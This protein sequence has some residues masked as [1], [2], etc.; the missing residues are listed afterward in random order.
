MQ[1]NDSVLVMKLVTR[2]GFTLRVS[3]ET[4]GQ[5]S[6]HIPSIYLHWEN[7]WEMEKNST[8]TSVIAVQGKISRLKMFSNSV[9]STNIVQMI[10]YW[11]YKRNFL[12]QEK[13]PIKQYLRKVLLKKKAD[14]GTYLFV[15][16]CRYRDV[17]V[18]AK[19]CRL[20]IGYW[21]CTKQ[22]KGCEPR[23]WSWTQ[24]VNI[25]RNAGGELPQFFSRKEQEE[26]ISIIKTSTD[27]F[28]IEA[29]FISLKTTSG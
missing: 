16:H 25:C 26:L 24:A 18:Q 22:R 6:Q 2:T 19:G 14:K 23:I 20:W 3:V 7:A 12:H 1:T 10:Y 27:Y 29:V 4:F 9:N 28:F 5:D 8:I 17:T 21:E 13:R 11:I 15:T